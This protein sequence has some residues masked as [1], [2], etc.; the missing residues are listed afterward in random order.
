[1]EDYIFIIIALVLS[2]FG[3]LNQQKKKR[4]QELQKED[5]M[6]IPSRSVF[7]EF[8]DGDP[9]MSD[10]TSENSV[11]P[12]VVKQVSSKREK[13][14]A[15]PPMQAPSKLKYNALK[16]ESLTHSYR[17][18]ERKTQALQLEKLKVEDDSKLTPR[19]LIRQ[20]FS[21]RKAVVYSEILNRK[22]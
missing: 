16:H 20:D 17:R 11:P 10:R 12:P 13:L 3:A 15:P 8:F 1:M 4:E 18:E 9:I 6:E 5:D 22:Y 2:V 7:E 19:N 21:L 14:K